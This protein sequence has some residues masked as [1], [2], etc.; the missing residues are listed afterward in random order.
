[1]TE[2]ESIDWITAVADCTDHILPTITHLH[3]AAHHTPQSIVFAR[4]RQYG[5]HLTKGS[6]GPHKCRQTASAATDRQRDTQTHNRTNTITHLHTTVSHKL[7]FTSYLTHNR[8]RYFTDALRLVWHW[9]LT[10][11]LITKTQWWI[12]D[13]FNFDLL[14]AWHSGRT[15]VCGRRTFPVLR[16]TCSW[17]V[18]TNV[19]KPSATGQP[20]RP[21]QPFILSGSIN[22]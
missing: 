13:P 3:T 2:V 20:T 19:G 21:T 6:S 22:E 14:V 18:T 9:S 1:M 11:S 8:R 12:S 5:P 7:M 4:W 17:W 10:G 15:S 16:L